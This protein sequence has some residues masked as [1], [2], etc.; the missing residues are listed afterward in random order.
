MFRHRHASPDGRGPDRPP[1]SSAESDGFPLRSP[2]LRLLNRGVMP[3]HS[4]KGCVTKAMGFRYAHPSYACFTVF[5]G[6]QRRPGAHRRNEIVQPGGR[7]GK[8]EVDEGNRDPRAKNDI[9]RGDIVMSNNVG[10]V[11]RQWDT[12]NVEGRWPY[13]PGGQAQ[14]RRAIVRPATA[15][16]AVLYRRRGARQAVG[17]LGSR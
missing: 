17:A 3:A 6:K 12:G 11:E 14:P 10:G 13:C 8:I 9:L 7:A 15:R 4:R 1:I 2:I 5:G 16:G